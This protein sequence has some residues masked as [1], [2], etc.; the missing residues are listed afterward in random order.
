LKTLA[1]SPADVA[2]WAAC[3]VAFFG[4]MR[5]STILP[6]PNALALG[7]FIS[8]GDVSGFTLSSFSITV[9]HSKKIQFGQHVQVL[10]FAACSDS[11]VCPVHAF[12]FFF[13]FG[14]VL[15]FC[16]FSI[17]QLCCRWERGGVYTCIQS[18]Q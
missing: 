1:D 14:G 4:F 7:K 10:P 12:F 5:K 17:V 18:S 3:L 16:N 11:R 15:T 2:F 9:K 8:I 6:L 13:F